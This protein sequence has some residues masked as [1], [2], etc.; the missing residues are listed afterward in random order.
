MPTYII[1]TTII[2]KTDYFE[3]KGSDKHPDMELPNIDFMKHLDQY[4]R[5]GGPT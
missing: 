4:H 2:L 1:D 3:C 5:R